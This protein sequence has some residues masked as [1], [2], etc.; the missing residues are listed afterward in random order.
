MPSMDMIIEAQEWMNRTY[1]PITPRKRWPERD[2]PF[3]CSTIISNPNKEGISLAKYG[4]SG[5]GQMVAFDKYRAEE[6]REELIAKAAEVL[7]SFVQNVDSYVITS[8][9]SGRN[10]KVNVFAEKVAHRIGIEYMTLLKVSGRGEQQKRMQNS[11]YQ[12]KNAVEK[13]RLEDNAAVPENIILIDDVS[14]SK[15]TLTVAGALLS[16]AGAANVVPFCLA[17]SSNVE[18]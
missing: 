4:D 9:P 16:N 18:S 15:W 5:Y 14:D 12:Y 6:Y 13:M 2:N 10:T 8:I 17:D 1:I 7:R 3:D 11:F